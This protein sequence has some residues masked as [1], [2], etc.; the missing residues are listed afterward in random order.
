MSKDRK[1]LIKF[2]G[3]V[4]LGAFIG[5]VMGYTGSR[6]NESLLEM[7][8]GLQAVLVRISPVIMAFASVLVIKSVI[9]LSKCKKLVDK[10]MSTQ[11]ENDFDEAAKTLETT[12][13]STAYGLMAGYVGFGIAMSGVFKNY[14]VSSIIIFMLQTVV[15]VII[16][17]VTTVVQSKG[18]KLDKIMAPE[19]KGNPLD[20]KFH[21]EYYDSCD[22][23]EKDL[24]GRASYKS[25]VATTTAIVIALVICI[26]MSAFTP[27]GAIPS[28][29]LV[30]VWFVQTYTF[31][32]E[33]KKNRR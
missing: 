27:I 33:S 12:L 3:I 5:A 11:E 25:Y 4:M 8:D 14:D 31:L 23:A 2:I 17:F 1:T 21:K 10:A 6:R 18:V 30:F 20:M 26:V 13:S 19:K 32:E 15:F 16:S 7:F 9:E 24:I 29:L 28:M 22:E